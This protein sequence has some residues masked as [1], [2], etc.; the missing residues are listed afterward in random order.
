M[1]L[2]KIYLLQSVQAGLC[3]VKGFVIP[4]LQQPMMA[5]KSHSGFPDILEAGSPSGRRN[6]D[7]ARL[8]GYFHGIGVA[9]DIIE[10]IMLPWAQRCTPPF[11][12]KELRTVI[13]SI[14]QYR[15]LA[16]NHGVIDPP[17]MTQA[18]T[19]TKYSWPDLG[20]DVLTSK[21]TDSFTYG[22]LGEVEVQTN[23]L[24]SIPKYLFGPVD[25]SWKDVASVSRL[26]EQLEKRMFGPPWKQMIGDVARLTVGQFTQ[27]AQWVKLREAPRS[28]QMGYA[29]RPLLLAKEPTLW[30]SAGGG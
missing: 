20:I 3:A 16:K 6:D 13:Q 29:H 30:F 5:S 14:G 10:T 21:T 24:I 23:N 8:V 19:A 11:D 18:G 25:V 1:L 15:Q 27:G 28:Q 4:A 17:V 26:T 22:I 12:R 9:K 7:A 2:C